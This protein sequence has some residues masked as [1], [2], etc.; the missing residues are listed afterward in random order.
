[1]AGV[2]EL[3]A[4]SGGNPWLDAAACT[5]CGPRPS[6]EDQHLLLHDWNTGGAVGLYA[7][8]DGHGGPAVPILAS[9]ALGPRLSAALEVEINGVASWS[10]CEG[11]VEAVKLALRE[12][13][14]QVKSKTVAMDSGS[15]VIAAAIWPVEGEADESTSEF[16]VLLTNLGDS[17][18]IVVRGTDANVL[19]ETID[20]KP[21]DAAE[22]Q[23][24]T[25]AGGVVSGLKAGE[26]PRVDADLA[27]SRSLGDFRLKD[28]KDLPPEQQKVSDVP[29]VFEFCCHSGDIIVLGCD[30]VFDV[31]TSCDVASMV[32]QE[33][34]RDPAAMAQNLVAEALR[35]NNQ[36]NVSCV[37]IQLRE[38][39]K[40]VVTSKTTSGVRRASIGACDMVRQ[41][42][43]A[44]GLRPSEEEWQGPFEKLLERFP[45]AGSARVAQA[46]RDSAGHGGKA[47]KILR[48]FQ[49]LHPVEQRGP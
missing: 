39:Y 23:R 27:M 16:C 15:T 13:D 47:A 44:P 34:Q 18:G 49:A 8:F 24:I 38:N 7:V 9:K 35:R 19:G 11:R 40:P 4:E 12:I 28:N 37:V 45:E 25:T 20:H 42:S 10:T 30:G 14:Q 41:L 6:N 21:D 3:E 22:M 2:G 26:C 46:M 32:C 5:A 29:D 36:D 43:E 17:R 1:M 33:P 48:S 31:L